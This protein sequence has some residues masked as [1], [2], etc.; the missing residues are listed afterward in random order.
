MVGRLGA[1]RPEDL[2][3]RGIVGLCEGWR[4]LVVSKDGLENV[5]GD[6]GGSCGGRDV[7]CRGLGVGNG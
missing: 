2:D 1:E 3:W 5:F 7:F 6:Q 4:E